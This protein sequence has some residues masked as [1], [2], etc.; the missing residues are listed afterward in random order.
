MTRK[1]IEAQRLAKFN[2]M[3]K[4]E[5]VVKLRKILGFT[6]SQNLGEVLITTEMARQLVE[7]NVHNRKI[8]NNKVVLLAKQLVNGEF[9]SD[10]CDSMIMFDITGMLVNGQHRLEAVIK[11]NKSVKLVVKLNCVMSQYTDTGKPRTGQDNFLLCEDVPND[12]KIPN[13]Y[14]AISALFNMNGVDPKL[15]R[16]SV[17]YFIN[18]H[19]AELRRMLDLGFFSNLPFCKALDTATTRTAFI[20]AYLDTEDEAILDLI[21]DVVSYGKYNEVPKTSSYFRLL[22]KYRNSQNNIGGKNGQEC[23]IKAV[24][25]MIYQALNNQTANRLCNQGTLRYDFDLVEDLKLT[26]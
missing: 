5:R 6:A 26:A 16:D 22:E 10:A 21:K 3:S 14:K 24:Q 4:D 2:L 13:I 17:I 20:M 15:H 11:A 19:N 25:C 12:L 7:F 9:N 8:A 1:E 23:Y 18:K